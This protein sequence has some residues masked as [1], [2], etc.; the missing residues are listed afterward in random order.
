[1]LFKFGDFDLTPYMVADSYDSQPN[2]RQDLDSYTDGYG[3]TR[4]N[5]LNHTKT[6][7]RFK[8]VE[9]DADTMKFIM[10]NIVRNY[11][12]FN[13][14]DNDNCS[15]FDTELFINKTGA[16]FYLDPSFKQKV[17]YVDEVTL[18][19]SR[20]GETTFLFTEY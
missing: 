15:Y 12:N 18:E 9:M 10:D 13:E 5:A 2:S 1:M 16:H 4:R 19:P 8:T 3:V 11:T 20:F 17:K 14:R 7:V 6:I